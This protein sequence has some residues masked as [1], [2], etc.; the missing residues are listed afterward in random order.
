MPAITPVVQAARKGVSEVVAHAVPR[1][2]AEAQHV[3]HGA[4]ASDAV[5]LSREAIPG[6]KAEG[7]TLIGRLLVAAGLKR[8]NLHEAQ[9][10]IRKLLEERLPHTSG[11]VSRDYHL[12]M[13]RLEDGTY[14]F[15][16]AAET[17]WN[18]HNREFGVTPI[19]LMGTFDPKTRTLG[20]LSQAARVPAK[21]ELGERI[22]ME[23]ARRLVPFPFDLIFPGPM[24]L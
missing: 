2:R 15:T 20:H 10:I 23:P 9:P 16:T 11:P 12:V 19:T 13:K 22:F 24:R 21:E 5:H 7:S 17:A 3:V 6:V 8:P 14:A 18:K 1:L 4:L